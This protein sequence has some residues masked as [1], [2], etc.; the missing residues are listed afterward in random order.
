[1]CQTTYK[2]YTNPPPGQIQF[3]PED[4]TVNI[5]LKECV[6]WHNVQKKENFF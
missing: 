3:S 4:N 1:M 2:I 5:I 6:A